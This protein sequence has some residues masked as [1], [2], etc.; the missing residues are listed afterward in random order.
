MFSNNPK[1][2]E[3]YTDTASIQD[4]RE[5]IQDELGK[6][7]DDDAHKFIVSIANILLIEPEEAPQQADTLSNSDIPENEASEE[8]KSN[9]RSNK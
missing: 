1:I 4:F 8:E 3:H 5:R 9:D 7:A 6:S 2:I